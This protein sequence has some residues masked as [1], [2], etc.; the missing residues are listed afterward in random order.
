M[1]TSDDVVAVLGAQ[2]ETRKG[3]R[4]RPR[5][6]VV[7]LA[8]PMLA[9]LSYFF[10]YPALGLLFSSIQTQNSQGIIGRPFTLAHYT[11]L[12]DVEL[13]ARVLWTTLRISVITSILA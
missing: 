10:F 4:W 11:R 6:S 5:L 8:I 7:L 2:P 3:S 9:F 1:T 12:I 13:Y